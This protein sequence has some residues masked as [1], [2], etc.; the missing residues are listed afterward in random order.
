MD[1]TRQPNLLLEALAYLG[2]KASGNTWA[3]FMQRVQ[4]RKLQESPSFRHT[5]SKLT[6][7]TDRMNREFHIEEEALCR[8]FNN[9]EGMPKNTIGSGSPAFLLFYPLLEQYEGNF[10]AIIAALKNAAPDQIAYGI[11]EVLDLTE[12]CPDAGP[13]DS[14]LF[15]SLLLAQSL[16]DQTKLAVFNLYTNYAQIAEE[17][18]VYLARV[19]ELLEKEKE[20]I[21]DITEAFDAE[22]QAIGCPEFL[23]HLSHL[24]P[25]PD[26]SYLLRPFLFGMDTN[27]SSDIAADQV[28]IYCGILRKVLQEMLNNQSGTDNSVYE[29]FRLLGDRTRFDI[30]CYLKDHNAYSQELSSH[31]NLS[32]NTIHHHM[33]RLIANNLVQCTIDGNRVYY[34]LDTDTIRLLLEEQKDLFLI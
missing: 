8:L 10:E 30:L 5:F 32:R 16:P 6:A 29:A 21:Y 15:L 17:A 33:S 11:L 26:T 31:F 28:C 27:I 7:L 3:Y 20:A 34:S 14:Q 23:G 24:K 9:L 4:Y 25:A 22:I 2:R 13:V 19:L 1:Y 12:E 18:A